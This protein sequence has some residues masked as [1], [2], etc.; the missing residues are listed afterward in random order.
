M[1]DMTSIQGQLDAE[2]I[3]AVKNLLYF[4]N[5]TRVESDL[6]TLE[7]L[8][9]QLDTSTL[10]GND[11]TE[12]FVA[13]PESQIEM[14]ATNQTLTDSISGSTYDGYNFNM[15][16]TI[17]SFIVPNYEAKVFID[18]EIQK[19]AMEELKRGSFTAL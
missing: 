7:G 16:F 8:R 12:I 11:R 6:I 14:T 5:F 2:F 3:E 13:V 19:K 17:K 1:A 15:G 4:R 18:Y 9:E 10:K